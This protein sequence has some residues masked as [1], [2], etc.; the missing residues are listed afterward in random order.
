MAGPFQSGRKEVRCYACGIPRP[1]FKFIESWRPE[2]SRDD[3]M[4]LAQEEGK[5][6]ATRR[7]GRSCL[8]YTS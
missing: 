1:Y 4:T 6:A 2:H 8:L 5:E 3:P 7:R